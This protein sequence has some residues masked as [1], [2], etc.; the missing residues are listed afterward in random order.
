LVCVLLIAI[1]ASVQCYKGIGDRIDRTY[2]VYKS[3]P[4]TTAEALAQGWVRLNS[5]CDPNKGI[6]YALNGTV[7]QPFPLSLF[8]TA[9]GNISA[10]SL[11]AWGDLPTS[12]RGNFWLPQGD[13]FQIVLSFRDP[14]IVCNSNYAVTEELGD[15]VIVNQGIT[16]FSIPLTYI[17]A[18]A[19]NWSVGGCI[20]KM[21]RHWS[22]DLA[23]MPNESWKIDSLMPVM[24]MYSNQTGQI[25]AILVNTRVVQYTEPVYGIYEEP[26]PGPLMCYNWCSIDCVIGEIGLHPLWNTLHF[27]FTDPQ[28]NKCPSHCW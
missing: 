5:T 2:G 17:D 18:G 21:G 7:N 11:R 20:E 1:F 3:L 8:F 13:H 26:L 15:R 19:Q 23:T 25:T 6:E 22:Y 10:F 14:Q 12:L 27:F 9:T 24:P 16:N 4:I 28:L